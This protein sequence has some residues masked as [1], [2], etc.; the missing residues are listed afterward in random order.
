[1]YALDKEQI[2]QRY[3]LTLLRSLEKYVATCA[4]IQIPFNNYVTGSAAF[5]HKAGVHSKAV[6]LNPGA[7]EIIDPEDF[8]VER[9]IQLAHR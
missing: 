6:M 7:Y 4:D 9:K 8:G 1:M 3:N 5:T 2:K